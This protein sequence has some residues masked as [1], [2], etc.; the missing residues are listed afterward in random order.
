M[1]S[2]LR[3]ENVINIKYIV[4]ILIVK[5]IILH[6]LARL[7]E[8][9]TRVSR[10]LVFEARIANAVCRRQ[11]TRESLQRLGSKISS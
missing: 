5:S 11:M 7:C 6:T 3:P 2:L 10:G 4:T 8:D 9:S 1:T